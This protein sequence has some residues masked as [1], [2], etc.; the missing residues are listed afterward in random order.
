LANHIIGMVG[1]SL[2]L[3]VLDGRLFR[4]HNM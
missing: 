4:R 1:I 2:G 3:L